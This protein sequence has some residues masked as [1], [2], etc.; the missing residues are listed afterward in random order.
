MT[1]TFKEVPEGTEV[2]ILQEG[3]PKVVPVE[4]A[5]AGWTSSLENLARLVEI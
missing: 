1:I 4:D 3:I 2:T 5:R